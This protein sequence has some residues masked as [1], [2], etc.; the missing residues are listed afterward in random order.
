MRILV[1]SNP[2]VYSSGYA[3]EMYLLAKVL[4]MQGHELFLIDCAIPSNNPQDTFNIGQLRALYAAQHPEFLANID[5]RMDVLSRVTFVRYMYDTFPRELDVK[6]FNDYI[7]KYKAD[8]VF[9]FIDIW[10]L[11]AAEC[12]K[13]GVR[14][15]CK[16]ACWLPLHFDPVEQRT[17]EAM[18]LFDTIVCLAK[19]GVKKTKALFPTKRILKVPHVIDFDKYNLDVI[20]VKAT[21]LEMGIPED[22]YLVTMI[23]N[24]SE[25]TNRKCF[26]T[27]IEAFNEF[28]KRHPEAKLYIHSKLTGS[29]DINEIIEFLEVPRDSLIISDQSKMGKGGYTFDFMVNLYKV[30][31]VLLSSTAS[32]GFGL[33]IL[34]ANSV[35]TA[36]VSTDTTAMPDH[37]YNGEL[38]ETWDAK[39][40]FLNTSRWYLPDLNSIVKCLERVY[41]RSPTEKK[42]KAAVGIEKARKHNLQLLYDGFKPVFV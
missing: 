1:F 35:G 26:E 3:V 20:D 22:C 14:F 11:K 2:V 34:E 16:S 7:D 6:D 28:R 36:V 29:M 38:A 19:D 23:F 30:T 27:N 10:I 25:N 39:M 32:E 21:R 15:N 8:Y 13:A 41:K 37:T 4:L 31:D 5:E 24:N 9:F 42:A 17:V 40:C 18:Q 12:L 33:P